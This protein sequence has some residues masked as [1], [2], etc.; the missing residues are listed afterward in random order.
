MQVWTVEE[1]HLVQT[2]SHIITNEQQ[3]H[4]L[5]VWTMVNDHCILRQR[6]SNESQVLV[7]SSKCYGSRLPVSMYPLTTHSSFADR[8]VWRRVIFI[9]LIFIF[10]R[11]W[12][13]LNELA[14]AWEP[15]VHIFIGDGCFH[16]NS[17]L[18]NCGAGHVESG[19]VL[20]SFVAI[21]TLHQ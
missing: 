18:R 13:G 15:E 12:R 2:S 6:C 16:Y 3:H 9:Y 14:C 11:K 17:E 10:R 19:T 21:K 7:V 4:E 5:M 1:V 20:H 8:T